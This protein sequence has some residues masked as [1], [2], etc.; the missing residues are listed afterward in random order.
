MVN[1][2]QDITTAQAAEV[3]DVEHRSVFRMVKRGELSPS[4][5]LPGRTGAYLFKRA[6]VERLAKSRSRA[7]AS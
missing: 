4:A 7:N 3:L 1:L 5:K 2:E 6:E